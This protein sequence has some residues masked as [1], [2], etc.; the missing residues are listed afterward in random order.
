MKTLRVASV[1]S[2][3]LKK[4]RRSNAS[5]PAASNGSEIKLSP[6][7]E[8]ELERI[9]Q[10]VPPCLRLPAP[11]GKCP[12]SGY[13]RGS[14]YEL[15]APCERNAFKPPVKAIYRKAHPH[16]VRGTWTII[17]ARLFRFLI[18]LGENSASTFI[19]L[20]K[21]RQSRKRVDEQHA[22]A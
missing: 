10:R 21:Q 18:S 4:D 14:L 16:A 7:G 5:V 15:I 3:G 8:Q 17:S 19:E 1:R 13:S 20:S 2:T 9:L 6:E 22:A 12:H 11:G